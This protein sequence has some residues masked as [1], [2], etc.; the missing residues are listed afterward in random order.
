MKRELV[1][2]WLLPHE[3][4]EVNAL[5]AQ[6]RITTSELVRR[7]VLGKKLPDT[8]RHEAVLEL[9][10]VNA[11]LARLGNLLRMAYT[12][13]S[14][15]LLPKEFDLQELYDDVRETQATLKTK[16]KEL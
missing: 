7:L 14:G 13:E 6:A 10:K 3:K 2:G 11:D 5:A 8:H 16:I 15:E 9:V 1:G 4:A 12:D